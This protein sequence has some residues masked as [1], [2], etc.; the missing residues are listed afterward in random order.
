MFKRI[1]KI[2]GI[3]LGCSLIGV[4]VLVGILFLQ[5]KFKKP[6]IEPTKIFFDY[7]NSELNVTYYA[8]GSDYKNVAQSN[9]YSFVLKALPED[10]TELDCAM[11]VGLGRDLISFCDKDGNPVSSSNIKIGQTVYFKINDV[12]DNAS[13]EAQKEYAKTNGS[14]NIGFKT[15]NGLCIADLKINID[16]A[17]K[18]VSLRDWNNS[19]NNLFTNGKFNFEN[20]DNKTLNISVEA[21]ERYLL[22]PIFAPAISNN[23][24][25]NKDA[26]ICKVYYEYKTGDKNNFYE[27]GADNGHDFIIKENGKYY[28][29]GEQSGDYLFYVVTYPTYAIQQDFL[30]NFSA[31]RE[32][33]D[34]IFN[35]AHAV[36]RQVKFTVNAS[37]IKTVRFESSE[38]E[39]PLKLFAPSSISVKDAVDGSLGLN[40]MMYNSEIASE[41]YIINS[42]YDQIKFLDDSC[43]IA[44]GIRITAN[45]DLDKYIDITSANQ[46]TFN[47]F[48]DEENG[49]YGYSIEYGAN[50]LT[51]RFTNDFSLEFAVSGLE[52]DGFY[53]I[54]LDSVDY[55]MKNGIA[56]V[57]KETVG[58]DAR[59]T[60]GC[61]KTGT[62]LVMANGEN[63]CVNSSFNVTTTGRGDQKT[64]TITP[65]E[66][67]EEIKLYCLV[68]NE[69]KTAVYTANPWSLTIEREAT[70]ISPISDQILKIQNNNGTNLKYSSINVDNIVNVSKGSFKIPFL[71]VKIYDV[72]DGWLT[73]KVNTLNQIRLKDESGNIY[74][75][76]GRFEGGA[77]VNEVVAKSGYIGTEELYLYFPTYSYGMTRA[78]DVIQSYITGLTNEFV[79][80][81]I[82]E[83]GDEP[84]TMPLGE[85]SGETEGV[86]AKDTIPGKVFSVGAE[87]KIGGVSY[88]ITD[89]QEDDV[90]FILTVQ[91]ASLKN[92]SKYSI[93]KNTDNLSYD[94]GEINTRDIKK[95]ISF[96]IQYVQDLDANTKLEFGVQIGGEGATVEDNVTKIKEGIIGQSTDENTGANVDKLYFDISLQDAT[97]LKLIAEQVKLDNDVPY[98]GGLGKYFDLYIKMVDGANKATIKN[99]SYQITADKVNYFIGEQNATTILNDFFS[100]DG[101]KLVEIGEKTY[102]R[103]CFSTKSVRDDSFENYDFYFG[104]S[105]ASNNYESGKINITSTAVKG[106]KF[107]VDENIYSFDDYYLQIVVSATTDGYV[108]NLYLKSRTNESEDPIL[109]KENLTSLEIFNLD[110]F[111]PYDEGY[112]EG[113]DEFEAV[114]SNI[115]IAQF[116]ADSKAKLNIFAL[117]EF[118]ITL[119]NTTR[120]TENMGKSSVMVKIVG[121]ENIVFEGKNS[122]EILGASQDVNSGKGDS[123]NLFE[124]YLKG[125]GTSV[126]NLFNV[127]GL[128]ELGISELNTKEFEY[129]VGENITIF[130]KTK[131][132]ADDKTYKTV[133]TIKYEGGKWTITREAD[134]ILTEFSFKLTAE[135]IFG[136][137]T[138][139]VNFKSTVTIETNYEHPLYGKTIDYYKG[140]KLQIATKDANYKDDCLYYLTDASSTGFK[141]QVENEMIWNDVSSGTELMFSSE[142]ATLQGLEEGE[143][144]A[145]IYYNDNKYLTFKVKIHENLL[146]NMGENSAENKLII[147]WN[148]TSWEQSL[149]YEVKNYSTSETYYY[150]DMSSATTV[151]SE[152]VTISADNIAPFSI[153]SNKLCLEWY[154]YVTN[155][156]YNLSLKINVDGIEKTVLYYVRVTT[157]ANIS[158]SDLTMD[159]CRDKTFNTDDFTLSGLE[160]YS[161]TSFKAISTTENKLNVVGLMA[162]E[163]TLSTGGRAVLENA[164]STFDINDTLF[165]L[166]YGSVIGRTI[167]ISILFNLSSGKTL[168]KEFNISVNNYS[169]VQSVMDG[170]TAGEQKDAKD[171]FGL[172][173]IWDNVKKVEFLNLDEFE[174]E[175]TTSFEGSYTEGGL[176]LKPKTYNG[177]DYTATIVIKLTYQNGTTYEKTYNLGIKNPYTAEVAYKFNDLKTNLTT[178]AYTSEEG[179]ELSDQ[180]YDLVLT[181]DEITNFA[182]IF[183]VLEVGSGQKAEG[184]NLTKIELFAYTNLSNNDISKIIIDNVN[185]KITFG[186][187]DNIGYLVFKLSSGN[188]AYCYYVVRLTLKI[189][190]QSRENYS[191]VI[192][193][194][195]DLGKLE[196]VMTSNSL[197][198][199]NVI[200]S[201]ELSARLPSLAKSSIEDGTIAFYIN[202]DQKTEI[203][204]T[205]I[206]PKNYTVSIVMK[207]VMGSEVY[208]GDILL[209]LLPNVEITLKDGARLTETTGEHFAYN[210]IFKYSYSDTNLNTINLMDEF[211]GVNIS[212][213]SIKAK[214][215]DG[216]EKDISDLVEIS[217]VGELTIKKN[218]SSNVTFDIELTS[219]S[220]LIITI[221]A[222]YEAYENSITTREFVLGYM[223]GD[224]K[225]SLLFNSLVSDYQGKIEYQIDEETAVT[226][227]DVET[228]TDLG[229]LFTLAQNIQRK[230]LKIKLSDID[231]VPEYNYEIKLNPN[232]NYNV[233]DADGS[234]STTPLADF[235]SKLEYT[236]ESLTAGGIKFVFGSVSAYFSVDAV[237]ISDIS[238]YNLDG[239]KL[240]IITNESSNILFKPLATE[241][242]G[243]LIVKFSGYDDLKIY[244]TAEK[245]YSIEALYRLDN[246]NYEAVKVG[247]TWGVLDLF[248][249]DLKT[250]TLDDGRTINASRIQLKKYDNEISTEFNNILLNDD[251][252]A[253]I[254]GMHF[255]VYFN[256]LEVEGGKVADNGTYATINGNNITFN[257]AGSVYLRLYNNIDVDF[258]YELRIQTESEYINNFTFTSDI[259]QGTVEEAKYFSTTVSQL[260]S[261]NGYQLTTLT[262]SKTDD[263]YFGIVV[264]SS[265]E[266]DSAHFSYQVSNNAVTLKL[267][268]DYST[269]E[270]GWLELYIITNNGVA[271]A[272]KIFVTN[273]TIENGNKEDTAV[274]AETIYAHSEGVA[275]SGNLPSGTNAGKKRISLI[276]VT[277]KAY[278]LSSSNYFVA[279]RYAYSAGVTYSSDNTTYVRVKNTTNQGVDYA[280][281]I[282]AL[283]GVSSDTSIILYYFVYYVLDE[284]AYIITNFSYALNVKNDISIS[285]NGLSENE[286]NV[287]IYLSN[288]K[289]EDGKTQVDLIN[290]TSDELYRNE[291]L[292]Y[293]SVNGQNYNGV[294]DAYVKNFMK[295]EIVDGDNVEV[296]D[297]GVL[298]V[299]NDNEQTVKLKV[300][301]QYTK[302]Y[303]KTFN[304]HIHPTIVDERKYSDNAI[305]KSL[306]SSGYNSNTNMNLVSIKPSK[307]ASLKLFEKKTNSGYVLQSN[308]LRELTVSY[309][310]KIGNDSTTL[311]KNFTGTT[312][313]NKTLTS[314]DDILAVTLPVVPFST[315]EAYCVTY[316][317]EITTTR[318]TVRTFYVN[319]LVKNTYGIT[320]T[321]T[322]TSNGQTI[323]VDKGAL[324]SSGKMYLYNNADQTKSLFTS[325]QSII[326]KGGKVKLYNIVDDTETR[327]ERTFEISKDGD[328]YYVTLTKDGTTP[329]FSNSMTFDMDI[330]N[331]SGQTLFTSAS[332]KMEAQDKIT[333]TNHK[334][335]SDLFLK[336]ELP[337]ELKDAEFTAVVTSGTPSY[338]GLTGGDNGLLKELSREGGNEYKF[339][340]IMVSKSGG[341]FYDLMTKTYYIE[342]TNTDFIQVN[343]YYYI[344]KIYDDTTSDLMLNW[345]E[346]LTIWSAGSWNVTTE[347]ITGAEMITNPFSSGVSCNENGLTLD[348]DGLQIDGESHT[349][350]KD[351]T[352]TF[353]VKFS[354]GSVVRHIRVDVIVD[355]NANVSTEPSGS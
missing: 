14:V 317:V 313:T 337:E 109:F 62:Y 246:V 45:D 140:T 218:I 155:K 37:T 99:I 229:A 98:L 66:W 260:Q 249:T 145:R 69:D 284:K 299:S 250:V 146:V 207:T 19:D 323:T 60:I 4:G 127:D 25:A 48:S 322:Y 348:V 339:C 47:G 215:S 68:I 303:S 9:I 35:N 354:Y 261:D 181:G 163:G 80:T 280:T 21:N 151:E 46:A 343:G 190:S 198:I 93:P 254:D 92:T 82:D 3:V 124:F 227:Y 130:D 42:R 112:P 58:E 138:T 63:K 253:F 176:K 252:S 8:N 95:S 36:T 139:T 191:S 194:D 293:V 223:N 335:F 196:Y 18:Q 162:S 195:R 263:N 297:N 104:F 275:L 32:L 307:D 321:E 248:K 353:E 74:V 122:V 1:L 143:Y 100:V 267:A 175:G 172:E 24:F 312:M 319:Y 44:G 279:Y 117:G 351:R 306:D 15:E 271:E 292:K 164:S 97:L 120:V 105:Y 224:F 265:S 149:S 40:I 114:S 230:T 13:E 27:V 225:T 282:F 147:S 71:F 328:D 87:I 77:F 228:D 234:I 85:T 159:A 256:S 90:N 39:L 179:F 111:A 116:D 110:N 168:E 310:Y 55:S 355:A 274:L 205:I 325:T 144:N 43:F 257:N 206:N 174:A 31:N 255:G 57:K 178:W 222:T 152:N 53:R 153:A 301:A 202:K 128:V 329:L 201:S 287:D 315:L 340:Y 239:D 245:T 327:D 295:F 78:N 226:N 345:S 311:D 148:G 330:Q 232:Y 5:G 185:L 344:S 91:D 316:K 199:S 273:I 20:E 308:D 119:K 165:T 318:G 296:A 141:L 240:D 22:E 11:S 212:E 131:Y 277:E 236:S 28:F 29:V 352:Y 51:L 121:D 49:A 182:D 129:E 83:G 231:G 262:Y 243:Y 137:V 289:Y 203:E 173:D 61:F 333:F 101:L 94:I 305:D 6:H 211:V 33:D 17:V 326:E 320:I 283:E 30:D 70:E 72:T 160:G 288:Y 186:N 336:S 106:Y 290:K 281:D 142:N 220:G 209:V 113:E 221:H 294:G 158:S 286:T 38:S 177:K 208:L 241:I 193:R 219:D 278:T 135:T 188:D 300:T 217:S 183:K 133:A 96:E 41:N 314:S 350:E 200:T 192:A 266:I 259:N 132:E 341:T 54:T 73:T 50:I 269:L 125:E 10:V 347:A 123:S 150:Y 2:F 189:M 166:N 126:T 342:T 75:L 251:G 272:I 349:L 247:E 34:L 324:E 197:T 334:K 115:K 237:N 59:Y 210:M 81:K 65:T 118:S 52:N 64:F 233:N 276:N 184:K 214:D 86:D 103:L 204:E 136:R 16:R 169:L 304:L 88:I 338:P 346:F 26:K 238:F 108:Y 235:S 84:E 154:P 12:F 180:K 89:I 187:C 268:G 171:I 302:S 291:Y 79:S 161:I 7:E 170:W 156:E 264:K 76:V 213:A 242:K 157:V 298:T 309:A 23:P 107:K 285:F 216:A 244:V 258:Y 167:T 102:I 134:Y 331:A 56:I 270:V 332:W 67:L